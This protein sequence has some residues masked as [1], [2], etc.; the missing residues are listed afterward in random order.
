MERDPKTGRLTKEDVV[1]RFWKKVQKTNTCWLWKG[2]LSNNYGS[3]HNGK[4]NVK[5]H[6]FAYELLIGK[7]RKDLSACHRCNNSKC[8][9]PAHIYIASHKENMIDAGNDNL[10]GS[11]FRL[12]V[13]PRGHYKTG[14]NGFPFKQNGKI[15]MGC[16]KCRYE[17]VAKSKRKKKL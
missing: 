8:V 10:L 5:A 17:A 4:K 7:I 3:F 12:I 2:A 13:C 1:V 6:R 9:N 15:T 16:R 11:K 14:K